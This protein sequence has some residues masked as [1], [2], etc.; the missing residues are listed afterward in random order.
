MKN[1]N[2]KLSFATDQVDEL[3]EEEY[4]KLAKEAE[5]VFETPEE[6]GDY[7]FL[8]EAETED[9]KKVWLGVK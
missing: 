6:Y 8:H 7:V 3:T 1:K 9:G 4:A 5:D 2:Y